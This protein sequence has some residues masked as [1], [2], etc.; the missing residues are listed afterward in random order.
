MFLTS[1]QYFLAFFFTFILTLASL[2]EN[3]KQFV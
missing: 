3:V 1:Q 2:I